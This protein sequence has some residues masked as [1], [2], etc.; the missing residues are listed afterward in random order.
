VCTFQ[1][2]GPEESRADNPHLLSEVCDSRTL[3]E[4]REGMRI[5]MGSLRWKEKGW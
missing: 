5:D 4:W 3:P 2:R 1:W